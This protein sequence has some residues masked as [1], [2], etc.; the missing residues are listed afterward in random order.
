MSEGKR[1]TIPVTA[2]LM[3]RKSDKL[4][5]M[6]RA[7]TGYEDGKYCFP[8]G[9]VEKGEEVT[10]AMIREAKE[11]IGIDIKYDDLILKHILNRKVKDNAYIDFIFECRNWEGTPI[12]MEKDHS[13]ELKWFNLD[14]LPENV[15]SFMK[16][17]F[18]NQN[19]IYMPIDWEE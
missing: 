11:E 3:L 15:I 9:H 17:V 4:L 1:N 14:E 16:D 8:G 18:K 10:K 7:N 5:L 2:L 19:K 13:D 12:I 6:R